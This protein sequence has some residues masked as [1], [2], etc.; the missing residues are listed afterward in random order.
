MDDI[1]S[2]ASEMQCPTAQ[3]RNCVPNTSGLGCNEQEADQG[4]GILIGMLV[5]RFPSMVTLGTVRV[6]APERPLPGTL[7]GAI[8][9]IGSENNWWIN[10]NHP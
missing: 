10:T 1:V 6:Q 3:Q 8:P 2:S 5:S 4:P 9:Q 7:Q